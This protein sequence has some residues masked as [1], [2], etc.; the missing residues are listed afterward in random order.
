MIDTLSQQL[1][2]I[3]TG[4]R[5]VVAEFDPAAVNRTGR[6]DVQV[7]SQMF[8]VLPS[9]T[10]GRICLALVPASKPMRW[11]R[12]LESDSVEVKAMRYALGPCV[13]YAVFG[14]PGLAV[15][16]WLETHQFD[17]AGDLDWTLPTSPERGHEGFASIGM[18]NARFMFSRQF[19]QG[20]LFRGSFTRVAC[21]GGHRQACRLAVLDTTREPQLPLPPGLFADNSYNWR[22]A[23]R[24]LEGG[25]FFSDL[26]Q[27]QGRDRFARF[28]RSP[29]PVDSAFGAA[30]GV[31]IDEWTLQWAERKTYHMPLGSKV[32]LGGLLLSLVLA[33]VAL[34]G[35]VALNARRQVG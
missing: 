10:D 23:P 14:T 21:A 13:Y 33:A 35:G 9:A 3:D 1:G 6:F 22:F 29:L 17:L 31:P 24:L 2:P 15:E 26:I 30:M 7:R 18:V 8:Y 5:L 27:S 4:I 12:S 34:A 19:Y 28:W 25:Y 32:P 11:Q 20:N 16:R